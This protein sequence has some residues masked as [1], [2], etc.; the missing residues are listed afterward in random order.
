M[1]VIVNNLKIL[2]MLCALMF[3]TAQNVYAGQASKWEYKIIHFAAFQTKAISNSLNK[4]GKQKWEL[5]QIIK[6][7]RKYMIVFKRKN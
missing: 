4:Y 3:F 7:D 2:A 1:R 5:V 6:A